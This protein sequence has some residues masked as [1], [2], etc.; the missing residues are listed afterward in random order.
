MKQAAKDIK[1]ERVNVLFVCMGNICRSLLAEGVFRHLVR[2]R[3][4]TD[5]FEIDSAGISGYHEGDPP[6]ARSAEVAKRRGI[7]LTGRSRRLKRADL[8]QFD[9]L[10]VM[11][12]ENRAGVERLA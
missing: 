11:D 7:E 9:Y 2:Q 4:L 6:D 1:Q 8:D 5:R 3:G 12:G 10:I